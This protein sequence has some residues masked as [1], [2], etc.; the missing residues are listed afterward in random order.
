MQNKTITTIS[1]KDGP[2]D[3]LGN[4]LSLGNPVVFVETDYR[5]LTM[6][7]IKKLCTKHALIQFDGG[8]TAFRLYKNIIKA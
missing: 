7:M 1:A 6:G 4:P 8:K 3:L 2:K 5:D